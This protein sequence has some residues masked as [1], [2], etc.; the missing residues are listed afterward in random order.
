MYRFLS[1]LGLTLFLTACSSNGSIGEVNVVQTPCNIGGESNL[2]KSQSGNLYLSW[3]EYENDTV[4]ILKYAK[5]ED[6]T[7]SVAR[8]IARGA[9]WFVNWADFPA[10]A[11]SGANDM[12]MAAHWLEKSA[13]GTFDYDVVLSQSYDGGQSW[14]AGEVVHKD[15]VHAEHGFVS[16]QGVSDGSFS[17]CWLDGR[18]TKMEGHE[19][20]DD[21]GH[22]HGHGHHGSMSLRYTKVLADGTIDPSVELDNK[23]CDCCQTDMVINDLGT[24]VVYRDRSDQEVRDIYIKRLVDG[25]WETPKA[26]FNDN[27]EI[28]A[29]PVNGPAIAAEG[30]NVIVFWYTMDEVGPVLRYAWSDDFGSTFSKATDLMVENPIGRVDAKFVN[31]D[32]VLLTWM[33]AADNKEALI[34]GGLVPFGEDLLEG[35]V[36]VRTGNNRNSGFPR[37]EVLDKKAYMTWTNTSVSEKEFIESASF[38][39]GFVD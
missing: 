26:V 14:S 15:S 31:S 6:D 4:S 36:I 2:F 32:H 16:I 21:H 25:Q 10:M 39:L 12:H 35:Q 7:W 8:E 20:E 5:W 23:V 28:A 18:N 11:V 9:N 37:I 17:M 13:A 27:W 24:L 30:S 33:E 3:I 29:C 1:I 19:H 22:D 34:M 38:D